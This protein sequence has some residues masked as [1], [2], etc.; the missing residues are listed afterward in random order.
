MTRSRLDVKLDLAM[1]GDINENLLLSP[2]DEVNIYFIYEMLYR[3]D[4]QI[5]GHVKNPGRKLYMSGMQI[6]DLVFLGGGFD[7]EIFLKN[8]YLDRA[9]LERLDDDGKT[10]NFIPFRLDSVLAGKGIA[11]MDV[12]M[13][14]IVRIYSKEEV[15]GIIPN[16]VSISGHVKKQGTFGYFNDV[17][18]MIFYLWPVV[19]KI[20]TI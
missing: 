9:Q 12:E 8:T 16:V 15:K 13:G 4:V 18:L 3:D 20:Q 7:D 11:N 19:L 14:D 1:N 5:L 6:F 10:R 17:S 2:N